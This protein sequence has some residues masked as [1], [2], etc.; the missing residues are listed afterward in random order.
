MT[1][2]YIEEIRKNIKDIIDI[3][4]S[5]ANINLPIANDPVAIDFIL[6][7]YLSHLKY[8]TKNIETLYNSMMEAYKNE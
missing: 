3:S 4:N 2:Q 1:D 6:G 7:H 5:V 8:A